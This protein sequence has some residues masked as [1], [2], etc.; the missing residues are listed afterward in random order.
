M[1]LTVALDCQTSMFTNSSGSLRHL[2]L[3]LCEVLAAHWGVALVHPVFTHWNPQ[4]LLTMFLSPNL[5]TY[6]RML[7]LKCNSVHMASLNLTAFI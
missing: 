1:R 6:L 5:Y 7:Q 2:N 4:G 3:S